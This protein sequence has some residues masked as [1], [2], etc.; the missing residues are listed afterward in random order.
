[1]SGR[2]DKRRSSCSR[3]FT[4][5]EAHRRFLEWTA[6]PSDRRPRS[7]DI[8]E[9]LGWYRAYCAGRLRRRWG[10][11]EAIEDAVQSGLI[12]SLL[13]HQFLAKCPPRLLQLKVY[14]TCHERLRTLLRKKRREV[15]PWIGIDPDDDQDYFGGLPAATPSP[16]TIKLSFELWERITRDMPFSEVLKGLGYSEK[17]VEEMIGL[18]HNQQQGLRRRFIDAIRRELGIE[19]KTKE[20]TTTK[21]RNK[22]TKRNARKRGR[23][24]RDPKKGRT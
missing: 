11:H 22:R 9:K 3:T 16:E 4:Q 12:D 24:R 6:T 1:M 14:D 7:P 21:K 20:T 23:R 15:S 19:K 10:R 13:S 8:D 2:A 5:E 17:D 18:S